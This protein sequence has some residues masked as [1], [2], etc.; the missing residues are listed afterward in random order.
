VIAAWGTGVTFLANAASFLAVISALAAIRTQPAQ[1]VVP[2]V[3]LL[4]DVRD[5]VRF[6]RRT[7]VV[8]WVLI[9]LGVLALFPMNFGEVSPTLRDVI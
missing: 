3:G 4:M 7:P 2:G 8:L 6:V 1:A 9:V 5:G